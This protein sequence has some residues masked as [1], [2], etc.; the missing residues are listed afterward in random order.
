MTY[1]LFMFTEKP[2]FIVD[3]SQASLVLL[4]GVKSTYFDFKNN[5]FIFKF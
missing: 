1:Y 3:R 5:K 4:L 2:L